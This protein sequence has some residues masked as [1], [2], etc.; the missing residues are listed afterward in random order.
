MAKEKKASKMDDFI[1]QKDAAELRGVEL[2]IINTWV[3]RKRVVTDKRYGKTLVSRRSVM[4]Y[5][6]EE[7][8]GGRGRKVST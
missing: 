8:K 2:S 1:T 4:A 7:N 5:K 3:R 6:P